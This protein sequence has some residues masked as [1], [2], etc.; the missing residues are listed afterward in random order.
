MI[1]PS[2]L[3]YHVSVTFYRVAE[4]NSSDAQLDTREAQRDTV[5]THMST[6]RYEGS[7]CTDHVADRSGGVHVDFAYHPE[8]CTGMCP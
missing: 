5:Q 3:K 1:A 4:I 2:G 7:M 8:T 6:A